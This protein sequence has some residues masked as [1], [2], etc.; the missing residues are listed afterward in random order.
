VVDAATALAAGLHRCSAEHLLFMGGCY[1][2]SVAGSGVCREARDGACVRHAEEVRAEA[3]AQLGT[4]QCVEVTG[5]AANTCKTCGAVIGGTKY[6]SACNDS[7]STAAPTDGVCTTDNAVC[8][9]KST[10]VCT[11]CTGSSFMF[12]GG[13]YATANAPGN[14]MCEAVN[15]G[16]CTTAKQGYFVPPTNDRDNS[17][18][19]VIPCG[20]DSV[21]TVKD[22]KQYKGVAN[23]LTCTAPVSG[24]AGTP[25]AATCIKCAD[26]YFINGAACTKCHESCLT[27]SDAADENSCTACAEGTHFLGATSGKGKCVSCGDA[28]GSTWKGV[29]NCAKC[30]KPVNENTPAVCTECVDNYYLKTDGATSCV[31]NCGEGFFPTT[32]SNTKKV[33]VSCGTAANGGIADCAKCSMLTPA[34]RSS[35]VLVTCTKCGSDKYLKSDGSGCVE[36]SG[37]ASDST[38]FAKE[39]TDSGNRCVSCGDQTDGGIADCKTCS[40]TDATLKCSTCKSGKKPNTA[41]TACVACSIENCASCDKENVCEAC[42]SNKKLSPLGDACLTDCPAG[43]YDDNSICKPCHFSCAECNSNANQDSC[44]ACYPGHV[45]NRTTD[46]GSTGTCIPECTGRYA[47]NCGA[48]MC[49][50][51]LGGSKYCSKCA[52]GYA[53]IDGVCTAVATTSRDASGCKASGGKCTACTGDYALLSGG[54][55]NTQALPGMAVCTAANSGSCTTCANGQ[56]YASGNCPACAEGCAEC[57]GSIS[58]CTKCLAGYYLDSIA[59]A[60]KK[61]S[62]NSNGIQGVPNC[63]SCAA[64]A[65]NSG[66]VTC[67]VTQEPTVDPADPSVNK[68]GLSSGAI[69]GISVAAIVVVGGF[70]SFLCWWFVC[71]TKK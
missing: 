69:A 68:G 53:P 64:P 17:H 10:G 39:D 19:S 2:I 13:C 44:T 52:V 11:T 57:K 26:G 55:Y 24:N 5:G 16:V 48:G 40:K 1:D 31:T 62:E 60:C 29:A 63:V 8:S 35:T 34:S 4:D 32:D 7:G 30:D 45:L 14:T 54:C 12:K 20:D 56:T 25:T 21:I 47:E 43:T 65:G 51:V 71:R 18:Q 67:Y 58:T 15:A 42:T 41:R 27:C 28:S 37:C 38:E 6:C 70:G 49:T 61:C 9:A 33:C 50:A 3:K 66:T 36:S 46:S 59:K 23:C 22:N